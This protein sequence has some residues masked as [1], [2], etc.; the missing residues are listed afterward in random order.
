MIVTCIGKDDYLTGSAF[1]IDG[2]S[3]KM[4]AWDNNNP[5][6]NRVDEIEFDVEDIHL[7]AKVFAAI[8]ARKFRCRKLTS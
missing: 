5:D 3:V 7:L 1:N 6:D 8:T 4:S 2:D